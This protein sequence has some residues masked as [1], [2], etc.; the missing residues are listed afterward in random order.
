MGGPSRFQLV[1]LLFRVFRA[2]GVRYFILTNNGMAAYGEE[3]DRRFFLQL[4]QILDP[5]FIIKRLL[6]TGLVE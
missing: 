1:K 5:T 2:V 6:Y 3:G 4:I